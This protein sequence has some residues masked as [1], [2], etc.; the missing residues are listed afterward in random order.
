MTANK[1]PT[2][3]GRAYDL[4]NVKNK[5]R[6]HSITLYEIFFEM[7]IEPINIVQTYIM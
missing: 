2:C 1:L 6:I 5:V 3:R 4:I 7:F